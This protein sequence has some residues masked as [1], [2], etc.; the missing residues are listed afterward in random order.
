MVRVGG[1][2]LTQHP[3]IL[4]IVLLL[5]RVLLAKRGFVLKGCDDVMMYAPF[6]VFWRFSACVCYML[7]ACFLVV[8]ILFLFLV[9]PEPRKMEKRQK[10]D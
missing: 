10:D 8:P 9:N 3:C 7:G 2:V 4:F 1:Y 5:Y 6:A